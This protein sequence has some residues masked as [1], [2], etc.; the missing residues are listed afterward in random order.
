MLS[1]QHWL[2]QAHQ[3]SGPVQHINLQTLSCTFQEYLCNEGF[4]LSAILHWVSALHLKSG[5]RPLSNRM[6]VTCRIRMEAHPFC[7]LP[8]V[9]QAPRQPAAVLTQGW[10]RGRVPRT[11]SPLPHP[12]AP[13]IFSGSLPTDITQLLS[14]HWQHNTIWSGYRPT[15]SF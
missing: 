12:A 13:G 14:F 15:V 11:E 1:I 2:D 3:I 7:S 10:L 4:S 5:S 6:D 8:L 9:A